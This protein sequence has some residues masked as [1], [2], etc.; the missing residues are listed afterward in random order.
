M[1][2]HCVLLLDNCKLCC[3]LGKE[4]LIIKR[5]NTNKKIPIERINILK[6]SFRFNFILLFLMILKVK[7][8]IDKSTNQVVT[9]L[10]H[11]IIFCTITRYETIMEE[12]KLKNIQAVAMLTEFS[13]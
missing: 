5:S 2:I 6:I 7:F 4:T 12:K 11:S 13:R 10:V 8:T 1:I 3:I 9:N